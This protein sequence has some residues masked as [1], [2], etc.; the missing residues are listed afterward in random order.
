M[1]ASDY[2]VLQTQGTSASNRNSKTAG[3]GSGVRK[4]LW[5]FG[6]SRNH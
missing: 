2:G 1:V 5:S 4:K 3:E 6:G